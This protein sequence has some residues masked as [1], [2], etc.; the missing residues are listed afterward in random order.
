MRDARS[1]FVEN[2]LSVEG[3]GGAP[4]HQADYLALIAPG[5]TEAMQRD[6]LQMNGCALTVRGLW[7]MA[8]VNHPILQRPYRIGM[9]VSDVVQIGK[10]A[11]AWR[12]TG[13][14]LPG[15]VFLIDN[16]EHVGTVVE[17]PTE[18][19]IASIDG[20]Q[21]DSFGHQLIRHRTR[22]FV[23]GALFG[24]DGVND[25][26]R[27]NLIGYIDCTALAAKWGIA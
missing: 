1:I 11:G 15:D 3:L 16:L 7:R 5:E 20:G 21:R 12:T 25:G 18:T 14:P 26:V 13:Q 27:R 24:N 10:D 4:E 8:G 2:A 23:D 6:M 9:A 22:V 19:E 17:R